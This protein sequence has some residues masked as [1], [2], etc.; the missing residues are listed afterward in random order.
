MHYVAAYIHSEYIGL[1]DEEYA[2]AYHRGEEIWESS[3]HRRLK[4]K[5]V[6]EDGCYIQAIGEVATRACAKLLG[7]PWKNTFDTFKQADLG[8]NI[9]VRSMGREWYG[10]R[11]RSDDEDSRRVIGVVIERGKERQQY[12]VVGW[13]N[14]KHAKK[15]EWKIDP[16]SLGRPMFAVP[17]D[18]LRGLDELRQL[19]GLPMPE[20]N[21]QPPPQVIA[22]PEPQRYFNFNL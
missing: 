3:Q 11:I 2:E 19:C 13:I 15:K 6:S 10:L 22:A 12:R 1:S 16:R 20:I 21:R 18:K 5:A 8:N 9:E 17:Q 14:A 7:L 4:E